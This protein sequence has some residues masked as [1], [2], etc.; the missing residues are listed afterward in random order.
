MVPITIKTTLSIPWVGAWVGQIPSHSGPGNQLVSTQGTRATGEPTISV[1]HAHS[2]ANQ[3]VD[4]ASRDEGEDEAGESEKK[5]GPQEVKA[6]S[7][8]IGCVFFFL[9][10]ALHYPRD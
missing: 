2:P 9:F 1:S 6:M 3:E 4:W 8:E 7:Q 10:W 5:T